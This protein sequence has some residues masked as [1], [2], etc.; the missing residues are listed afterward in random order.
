M[1]CQR[2]KTVTCNSHLL[3]TAV[4]RLGAHTLLSGWN[5]HGGVSVSLASP[6]IN[7]TKVEEKQ[8]YVY[9]NSPIFS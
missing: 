4:K 1:S 5:C 6:T 9:F 2:G 3:T 8:F 7:E